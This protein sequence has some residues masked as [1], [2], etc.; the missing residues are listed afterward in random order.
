MNDGIGYMEYS[1][2]ETY[3]SYLSEEEKKVKKKK[4]RFTIENN[5]LHENGKEVYGY[6]IVSDDKYGT[7]VKAS[8]ETNGTPMDNYTFGVKVTLLQTTIDIPEE[9]KVGS[10][11]DVMRFMLD[12]EDEEVD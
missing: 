4:S 9:D 11:R 12:G 2:F 10:L 5:D 8:Y 6:S 3:P 1:V 7:K